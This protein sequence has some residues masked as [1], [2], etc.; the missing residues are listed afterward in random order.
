MATAMALYL[1]NGAGQPPYFLK[2]S[3]VSARPHSVHFVQAFAGFLHKIG[4]LP[5]IV[6]RFNTN[7]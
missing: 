6:A 1:A 7:F 5:E 4:E 2:L 3:A